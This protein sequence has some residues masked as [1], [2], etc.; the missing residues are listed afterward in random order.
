MTGFRIRKAGADDCDALSLVGCAAFV[1]TF[2]GILP[3]SDI[4][5]HC[6][7]KLSPGA[8]RQLLAVGGEAWLV[9]LA[10]TGKPIG[11]ALLTKPDLPLETAAGDRELRRIYFLKRA[12]GTG[13]A[14]Q[15]L[16]EIVAALRAA[17]STRLLLGVYR[18]NHRACAFYERYG[19]VVVGERQY[20]VGANSYDDLVYALDLEPS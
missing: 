20:R 16:G 5:A 13:A 1:E 17:G 18:G 15:L 9:E 2:T 3:G 7:E 4:V 11:Y 12:Q 10:K 14:G 6:A 19:F 8:F